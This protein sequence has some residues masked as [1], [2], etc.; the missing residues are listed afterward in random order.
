VPAK[1]SRGGGPSRPVLI[2]GVACALLAPRAARAQLI[3]ADDFEGGT[4][5]SW[6]ST[7]GAS[8]LPPEIC[9]PPVS[10]VDTSGATLVGTGTPAS[11]SEAAFDAALL[12]NNGA[13]R[14]DCGASPHTIVFSS[15]KTIAED[16]V[17]DGGGFVTLSGGGTTRILAM[18]PPFNTPRTLTVQN[19]TFEDGYTGDQPGGDVDSGGG[20]IYRGSFGDLNVIDSIFRNNV[21]PATGQ[22][23]AGGAIYS[24]G[25]G[26]TTVVGSVFTG[27]QC[28]SGGALGNLANDLT[29]Y[30]SILTG[31]AATGSGGNP[32]NGGNGGGIYMDGN[33]QTVD[34]CGTSISDNDANAR[35]GGFFRVS[36]NGV[37]P[38]T[39]DRSTISDNE[40][41]ANSSSQAGGLY[42]QGLQLTITNTTVSGNVASSAGG[43]FVWTN[44]GSQTLNM[45]NVTVA[46][47]HARTNLGAG[48]SVNSGVAGTLSHVT[49]ARNSQEGATSFASAL[50]GGDGLTI[51]NSL[52]ADN[53]KVFIW[54][55]TS[56]NATHS[57]SGNVQWPE[58]NAGGQAE[59]ACATVSFVDPLIGP[60]QGNGGTTRTIVPAEPSIIGSVNSGCAATDQRGQPRTAPCTPGAV[61]P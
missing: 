59:L 60:L 36:N 49:I 50:A 30:N 15:E 9:A 39:I 22:D 29:V 52:I 19:L 23:V 53:S 33:D 58:F 14:F 7:V 11:C 10:A 12:S 13:I 32:G 16:L 55:N 20:A 42:L 56:C 2:L 27:N 43:M 35:G 8:L 25:S 61:E 28:S 54:E 57:G 31:N 40:I 46:E 51:S 3:F 34:V 38:M 24:R 1:T 6:S 4:T 48:M 41:P 45:T 17:I 44:P 18:R 37:G 21:G 26:T 5:G 47:N